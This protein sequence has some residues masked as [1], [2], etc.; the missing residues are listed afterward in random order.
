MVTDCLIIGYNDG[1]FEREVQMMRSMGTDHPDYRDLNLNFIEYQGKPYRAMD[2][3][4]HFHYEGR[5]DAERWR[6][7][8]NTDVLWMV[9]MYLGT[10]LAHRGFSFDYIN[11]FQQQKDELLE[12]LRT[13]KYLA[14]VVTTTIY[15]YD[16]PIREV[17]DFLREHSPETRIVVG[18]PYVAKRSETM[19]ESD[20]KAV[21]KYIGAD[22]YVRSREGEQVLVRLLQALKGSQRF[23]NIPNFAYREN[24]QFVL[25]P[26]ER[27]YNALYEN[28]IDYSLFPSE[29]VGSY[30]NVRI[31]KGCPFTCSFCSFPLRTE[32]YDVSRLEYIERELNAIRD[33]GTVSGL[34][35]VDDT[36]NVPLTTFKEM[37]RM[38]I[39]QG[40]GFKWHCFFRA[41]FCDAELVDLMAR[42]GC[43]G[44]FLGLESAN[45]QML[46]NMH[47]TP[48]KHHYLSV[49][50]MFKKAGI[51]VFASLFFG[52]P[53]E[54][55]ATAQETMDFLA[56]TQPDFYRPL[57]WYCD[58]VTPIWNERDRYGI[59]GYHF[60]W[61]HD[62]MDVSTACDLV[63]RCFFTFDTPLWVP[64]PG[65]NFVSLFLLQNRGMS[66]DQIET[67]LRSFNAVVR[68][69]M[70]EPVRPEPSPRV[71]ENLRRA[72]QFD[73]PAAVDREVF[74][75]AS[76]DR[77]TAAEQFWLSELSGSPPQ[78]GGKERLASDAGEA[79][80]PGPV[81]PLERLQL[82]SLAHACGT[83]RSSVLL[84]ALAVALL[85]L[86]GRDDTAV[87][88]AVGSG[89]PFPV[90][91][92]ATER[93]IFRDLARAA[94]R[95]M[96]VAAPH[97]SF[98]PIILS[99]VCR[100]PGYLKAPP[101]F[102]LGYLEAT[103]ASDDGL[104]RFAAP[105]YRELALILRLDAR[106]EREE[107]AA[108]HL[109]SSRRVW[110]P[111]RIADLGAALLKILSA[112][113][114]DPDV[115]VGDIPLAM[116][117]PLA[118]ISG[119]PLSSL[120]FNF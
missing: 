28:I 70:L 86:E 90:R 38:M 75:I 94:E 92:A 48:R 27:E 107:G 85:R 67:F 13:R 93:S 77:Y 69:K 35:F 71:I 33:V 15:N 97:R 110:A 2:I 88:A 68:E 24:G 14:A 47:K 104:L 18:G 74:E 42:A 87:V 1:Q 72:C 31:T 21:F 111:E 113:A 40:Y 19:E 58:P 44:V 63:E 118:E 115:P 101:T 59:E 53:G 102:D 54:T 8:H 45:D 80:T 17:V 108:L 30:V 62:T 116:P 89:A 6:K 36:A 79:L 96:A 91:L 84:A 46:I 50:P 99:G 82:E 83:E 23:A 66:F 114:V 112:A 100:M 11:L 119:R 55:H 120:Q 51:K 61:S 4:D 29:D 25:T 65:F 39:R 34:F 78:A 105:H 98:A 109:L 10:Y 37:M 95:R 103:S 12:K 22:F 16:T 41:D 9:V 76:A 26:T 56:E 57:V 73:R 7:F 5:P 43:Q 3:L 81:L 32:K 64:D 52:F 60:S 117:V 106:E 49:V 20:L